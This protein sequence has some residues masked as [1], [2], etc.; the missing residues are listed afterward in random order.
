MKKIFTILSAIAVALVFAFGASAQERVTVVSVYL[1]NGQAEYFKVADK[2]SVT[3][4]DH[5]ITVSSD[6]LTGEYNFDDVSHFAFED[7]N[8]VMGIEEVGGDNASF[9]FV[10]T[11]NANVYISA[12]DLKWAKVFSV[13]GSEVA[14]ATANADGVVTLNIAGLAPGVYVVTPSCHSAVKIVKR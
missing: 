12:P 4:G 2:P 10:Y 5:K 13:Q 7:A 8:D 3:F 11:D 6:A 14:A 1:Q 9:T